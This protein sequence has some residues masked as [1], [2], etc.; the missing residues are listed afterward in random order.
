MKQ[1]SR[2]QISSEYLILVGF[3][4]FL[5]LVLLGVSVFYT[6]ATRDRVVYNDLDF[7]A[8][9]VIDSAEIVYYA[10][11]PSTTI[12][13]PFLPQGVQEISVTSEG[14]YIRLST[15]GGEARLAYPSRVPLAGT[16]SI[17]EGVKRIRVTAQPQ[18]VL[19]SEEA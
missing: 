9:D 15:S 13:R 8:R 12:I 3:I 1:F 18:Q 10:G 11:E 16:L 17:G 5:V 4:T 2:G 14:L 6:A 19:I 7:F